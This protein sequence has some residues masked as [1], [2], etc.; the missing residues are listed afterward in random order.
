MYLREKEDEEI[1]EYGVN[2]KE[3]YL[4]SSRREDRKG[5]NDKSRQHISEIMRK[6]RN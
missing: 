6:R 3:K 5:D 2:E 1:G 4:K